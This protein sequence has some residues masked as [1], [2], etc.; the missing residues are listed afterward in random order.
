MRRFIISNET[1][2]SGNA[3]IWYNEKGTLCKIDCTQTNMEEVIILNFKQAIPASLNKLINGN[4]FSSETTIVEADLDI[5]FD[6]FWEDY[7]K[8][9][10]KV[11]CEPLWSKMSKVQ[12][13]AA[14][15]GI[16]KYDK[17]LHKESW[18][19]KSDPESYLRNR[20]WENEWR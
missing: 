6:K 5:T 13:V 2:F 8:K 12:Q 18:R 16:G 4:A 14:Y 11:R 19:S 7:R 1:K 15:Y 9:I 20:M 3:E 10:N 17:Y